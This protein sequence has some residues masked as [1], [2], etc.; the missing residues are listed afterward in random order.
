[1]DLMIQ[2]FNKS[3][4]IFNNLLLAKSKN[5]YHQSRMKDSS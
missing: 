4:P 5:L 2:I 3:K 1:M